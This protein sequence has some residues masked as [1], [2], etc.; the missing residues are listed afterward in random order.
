MLRPLIGSA[1]AAFSLVAGFHTSVAA[2]PPA[3][4]ECRTPALTI[5]LMIEIA[6]QGDGTV[7]A[8]V[9]HCVFFWGG[10]PKGASR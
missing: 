2:A 1:L 8:A 3:F 5:P 9:Q 6:N 10:H 4:I 7:R